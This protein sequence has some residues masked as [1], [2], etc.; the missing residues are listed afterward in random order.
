MSERVRVG[1]LLPTR[2]AVMSGRFEA[3][4]LLAMAER[5]EAAGYDSV[6]V[7]DSILARPRHEP[8]TLLAAVAARTR[9]VQLGT[10]VL[11]PALRHPLVLAHLVA[12]VDR[13]AEGRLLLGVG[14]AP[15]SPAVRREFA[16]SGVPFEQRVGRLVESLA[17][18]RRLWSEDGEAGVTFA[19]RYWQVTGARLLPT[20]HRPGGPPVWMGG[21][22]EAATRRAGRLADAW[23]P[24][25]VT[26]GAWADGW[27]R[28]RA[29]AR[30][31][32][33][34]DG[35]LTPAL[36]TTLNVGVDAR[37]A[38]AALRRF[39][40]AYYGAP[41]EAIARIQGFHAGDT[42]SC[43]ER[44]QRFVAAG[45]RHVVLRFGGADQMEQ[46]ERTTREILPRLR[47]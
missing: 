20:P 26:P 41:Y 15:D 22:V 38:D 36:Y 32:R 5:A 9:R 2:D 42:A 24:N 43:L 39:V 4:P 30:A 37:A 45:V 35:H 18:C 3:A 25:S 8:L 12:T 10:A 19:G 29:T 11:L 44:L 17:L 46:L 14:I 31:E 7:G 1:V 28:V 47:A 27:A 16:A 6:W 33:G 21:E 23:L 40:E 34:G 13:I